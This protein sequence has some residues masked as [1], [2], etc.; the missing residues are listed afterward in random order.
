MFDSHCTQ[1]V[2]YIKTHGSITQDDATDDIGCKRLAARVEELRRKGFPIVTNMETGLNRNRR[3]VRYA[4]YTI[5]E[6]NY[7]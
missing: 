3:P 4:R 5:E 6:G 1:I 2:E 7:E